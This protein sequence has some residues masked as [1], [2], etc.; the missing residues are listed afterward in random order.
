MAG[1]RRR[2]FSFFF[3]IFSFLKPGRLVVRLSISGAAP[4]FVFLCF[5]SLILKNNKKKQTT[6]ANSPAARGRGTGGGGGIKKALHRLNKM[7]KKKNMERVREMSE[8]RKSFNTNKSLMS[9]N[10][11]E[12]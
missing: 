5:F 3:L 7:Q 1:R 11:F 9:R 12:K 6:A 4:F 2:E 10:L 8:K